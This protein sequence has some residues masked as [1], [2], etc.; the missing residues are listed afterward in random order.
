[1][2][3]PKP[4][5][6]DFAVAGVFLVYKEK[7]LY[8]YRHTENCWG[9]PAGKVE[10]GETLTECIIRE[11]KEEIGVTLHPAQLTQK[12]TYYLKHGTKVF[13]YTV[14]VCELASEPDILLN[15][16]HTDY[17]WATPH[18]ALDLELIEDEDICIKDTFNV[19][20]E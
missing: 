3:I 4:T 7:S 10:S 19:V 6:S 14:F 17:A 8:L 16:E 20:V 18:E 12:E 1:M 5:H 11:V 13:S 15:A 9:V 2:I